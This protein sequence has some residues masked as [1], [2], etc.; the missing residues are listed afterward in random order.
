MFEL[1]KELKITDLI[2]IFFLNLWCRHS[3]LPL[4]C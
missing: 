2:D 3:S 4:P 1:R